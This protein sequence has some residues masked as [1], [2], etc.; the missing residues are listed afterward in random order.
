MVHVCQYD[1]K[2]ERMFLRR[3][4]ADNIRL[5]DLRVGLYVNV[6]SRRLK[7]VDYARTS[8]KQH[9]S[10]QTQRYYRKNVTKALMITVLRVKG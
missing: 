10:Q 4:K 1:L 6:L 8:T 2:N 5:C 3:V 9:F 7:I